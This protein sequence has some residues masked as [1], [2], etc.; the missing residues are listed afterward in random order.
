ML[1]TDTIGEGGSKNPFALLSLIQKPVFSQARLH[2]G[3]LPENV[4]W[5]QTG[6]LLAVISMVLAQ[7]TLESFP[8]A[9]LQET[10]C[11]KSWQ[12]WMHG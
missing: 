10:P 1:G 5:L 8:S 12:P 6:S 4:V 3:V 9:C 11:H 7:S 2:A